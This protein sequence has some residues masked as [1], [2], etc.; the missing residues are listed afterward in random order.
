MRF[1]SFDIGHLKL[2]DSF[3]FMSSSLENLVDNLKDDSCSN[4]PIIKVGIWR[5]YQVICRKS[6]YPYEWFDNVDKLEF[7]GLP[8]KDD[9]CSQLSQQHID[10]KDYVHAKNVYETMS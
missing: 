4:F 1:M 10:D 9:F 8:Q 5:K 6:F 7:K 2:I 3:Q